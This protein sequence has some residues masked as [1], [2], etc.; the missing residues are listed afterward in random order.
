[1]EEI[2]PKWAEVG[3]EIYRDA[4]V[5]ARGMAQIAVLFDDPDHPPPELVVHELGLPDA[6]GHDWGPHSPELRLAVD[7]CDRRVGH[8]LE[9]LEKKNLRRGTLFVVTSDHGMACQDV[10][11]AANPAW[12]PDRKGMKT[13]TA[14]PMVWLRDVR[15]VVQRAS[16][17]RTARVEVS[18]LDATVSGE[19]PPVEGAEVEVVDNSDRRIAGGRTDEDGRFAFGTPADIP[20]D[21]IVLAV[22]HPGFNSRHLTLEGQPFG[23]DPRRFYR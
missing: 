4:V 7:E 10:S 16:D 3:G 15:V 12:H 13:V 5:D 18:E 11:L 2:H 8:I 19:H 14:E 20:S 22:R 21:R 6:V 17:G 9:T 1:M 23:P